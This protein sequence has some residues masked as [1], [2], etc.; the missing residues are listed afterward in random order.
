M[1][2]STIEGQERDLSIKVFL[3]VLYISVDKHCWDFSQLKLIKSIR[4]QI[5]KRIPCQNKPPKF[6]KVPLV[7]RE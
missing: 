6:K 4:T 2:Q 1:W 7:V 5:Q 3:G